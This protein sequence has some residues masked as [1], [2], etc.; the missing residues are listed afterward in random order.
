MKEIVVILDNVRSALNVGNIFRTSDGAGV[1]KIY[2]LGITPE[3]SHPKVSKTALGAEETVPFEKLE[4]KD[5]EELILK[6]INDGFEIYSI[7]ETNGSANFFENDFGDRVAFVFGHEITGVSN[8]IMNKSKKI[9]HLPMQGEK[10]SLNVSNTVAI[11]L[12]SAQFG[13]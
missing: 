5:S 2:L 7:E 6:L 8:E 12:Y 4:N 10:N 3:P 9:L 1:S 11:V 13:K